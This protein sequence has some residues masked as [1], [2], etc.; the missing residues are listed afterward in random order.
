MAFM[1]AVNMLVPLVQAVMY[2]KTAAKYVM[3]GIHEFRKL[4]EDGI[5]PS[6]FHPGR[7]RRISLKTDLDEY[8]QN[9]P[10]ANMS[11]GRV[12]LGSERN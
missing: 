5:I 4:V 1:P 11:A 7:T 12:R 10:C 2:E 8:L 3:L 9:L 6:R